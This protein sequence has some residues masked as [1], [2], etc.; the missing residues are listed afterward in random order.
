L[1]QLIITID[2]LVFGG[3]DF[4]ARLETL[5]AAMLSQ[6]GVRLPGDRRLA[7]RLEA[8]NAGVAISD[9]LHQRLLEYCG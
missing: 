3:T 2:P 7:K 9:E 6:E 5:F 4:E 1:G 8:R